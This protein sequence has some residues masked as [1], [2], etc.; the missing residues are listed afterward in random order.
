MFAIQDASAAPAT[1][2]YVDFLLETATTCDSVAEVLAAMTPCMRL[3]AFIGQS[4]RAAIGGVPDER[5]PYSRWIA[6]YCA[7]EFSVRTHTDPRRAHAASSANANSPVAT[8]CP[9]AQALARIMEDLLDE[10]AALERVSDATLEPLYNAAMELELR[11]FEQYFPLARAHSVRAFPSITFP[12]TVLLSVQGDETA[13]V[14][15][16]TA[17][18]LSASVL[19]LVEDGRC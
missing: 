16:G 8:V 12:M 5:H 14:S 10:T 11:F 3:Y 6:S 17:C 4:I 9:L 2:D 15:E 19:A 18:V 13:R 7:D 1:R